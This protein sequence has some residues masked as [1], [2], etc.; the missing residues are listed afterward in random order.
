MT[1]KVSFTTTML[2][3]QV[4]KQQQALMK[5]TTVES[6]NL[7]I[8]ILQNVCFG[9]KVLYESDWF[10]SDHEKCTQHSPTLF[11]QHLHPY[12]I[13]GT[14]HN[15]GSCIVCIPWSSQEEEVLSVSVMF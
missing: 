11:P 7:I 5:S 14:F 10:C 1:G 9:I 6:Q 8:K 12:E 2:V 13:F 4:K 15:P 3:F